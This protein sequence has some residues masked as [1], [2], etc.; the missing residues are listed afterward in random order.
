MQKIAFKSICFIILSLAMTL[1]IAVTAGAADDT[2]GYDT[3]ELKNGDK[4]TGTVLNNTFTVT[5][6]YTS[7][8]LEKDQIS[9]IRINP[10]S[11]NHDVIML[12]TGGLLEGTI[13]ESVLSFKLVSGQIISLEKEQCKKILLENNNE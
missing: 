8:T 4:V 13:E 3:A 12:N 9:E 5:T 6:P 7:T 2:D 10:E 11:E 1:S